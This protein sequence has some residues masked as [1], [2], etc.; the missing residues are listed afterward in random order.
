MRKAIISG[1]SLGGVNLSRRMNPRNFL[2]VTAVAEIPAGCGAT[3]LRP[4]HD[5]SGFA[6]P[7][8]FFGTLLVAGI[9]VYMIF[10]FEPLP[11]PIPPPQQQSIFI[12]NG[13]L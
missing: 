3:T 1:I 10:A 5:M 4:G 12:R 2:I 9:A 7:M 13:V 11:G 8:L 6:R